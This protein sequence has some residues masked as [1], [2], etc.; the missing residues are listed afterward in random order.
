MTSKAECQ[1]L[2]STDQNTKD[3]GDLGTEDLA[4]P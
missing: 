3:L 4:S 2:D 1:D